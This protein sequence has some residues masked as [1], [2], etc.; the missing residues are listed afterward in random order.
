[1]VD[2]ITVAMGSVH[3]LLK[4]AFYASKEPV[5]LGNMY[6]LVIVTL[7]YASVC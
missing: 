3:G 5:S 7:F 2:G 6:I 4:Q 1:M